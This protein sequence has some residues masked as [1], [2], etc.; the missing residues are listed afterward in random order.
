MPLSQN[1]K[2]DSN[3]LWTLSVIQ[4]QNPTAQTKSEF[5]EMAN[6]VINT[7]N[8][9]NLTLC[10]ADNLQRFRL[11]IQHGIT[12]EEATAKCQEL[13]A[14]WHKDNSE[15]VESLKKSKNFSILTWQEFLDWPQKD[16]TIADIENFYSENKEFRNDVDTRVR[17][18]RDALKHPKISD[19]SEQTTLLRKY[20]I[21]EMAFQK[22][23]ASKGFVYEI[24]KTQHCKAMRKIKHNT[25]FVPMGLMKEVFFTQF[26]PKNKSSK[27]SLEVK[28]DYPVAQHLSAPLTGFDFPPTYYKKT[29]TYFPSDR[30]IAEE[31]KASF[32][33]VFNNPSKTVETNES[34][35]NLPVS[36]RERKVSE[37]IEKTLNLIPVIHQ[38]KAIQE[39]LKFTTEKLMPMCYVETTSVMKL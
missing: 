33:S 30:Q 18:A 27:S 1:V 14:Q 37:L 7:P 2:K 16:K 24:Y 4:D 21:E 17:Q 39:L 31:T 15:S 26:D 32:S 34:T 36:S 8:V 13:N 5:A 22:F 25:D 9:T 38:E 12:E 23:A 20:L 10:L 35:N 29:V 6:D 28:K 11:M 19:T 3:V